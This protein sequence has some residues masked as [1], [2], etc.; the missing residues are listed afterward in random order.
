MAGPASIAWSGEDERQIAYVSIA[1]WDSDSELR[2][3]HG[4]REM[5][6]GHAEMVFA[7]V[8]LAATEDVDAVVEL[9]NERGF[10]YAG[11]R[12]CALGQ[13]D[14]LRLQRVNANNLEPQQIVCDGDF[15]RELLALVH[16]DHHRV[17]E[18]AG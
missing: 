15:G 10:F 11:L 17:E 14:A 4:L 5:L 6:A 3:G 7:D 18:I 13:H 8:D 16:E 12:P 2:F 9:L 1:G